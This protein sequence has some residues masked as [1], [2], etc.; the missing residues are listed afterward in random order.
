MRN[1]AFLC[2]ILL[3]FGNRSL[4]SEGT[5]TTKLAKIKNWGAVLAGTLYSGLRP[6][7][8]TEN[9]LSSDIALIP[10]YKFNKKTKVALILAGTKELEGER[11][12]KWADSNIYIQQNFN[13][14]GD[15]SLSGRLYQTIPLS[16]SST[17]DR[18]LTTATKVEPKLNYLF[19]NFSFSYAPSLKQYFYKFKTSKTGKINTRYTL[20]QKA[21]IGYSLSERI[22]IAL[23][24]VYSRAVNYQGTTKD[25]YSFDQSMTY[26]ATQNTSLTLGHSTGGSPLAANGQDTQIDIFDKYESTLYFSAG[27]VY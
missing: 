26:S 24:A 7:S 13:K 6:I 27:V 20:S 22:S 1:Y 4:G 16:E 19:K 8:S 17:K 21:F 18:N 2:L 10:N 9:Q 3:T 15:F 12:F 23:E 25:N 14:Y 5:S 11:K